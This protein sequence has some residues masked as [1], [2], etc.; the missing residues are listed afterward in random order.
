MAER[1]LITGAGGR[2]GGSLAEHKGSARGCIDLI[3][4]MHLDN[5]NVKIFPERGRH[6]ACQGD[7]EIDAK[8][9]V[10]GLDDHGL[11]G[12][13]LDGSLACRI[14][15]G[16]A[17]D[18]DGC[19]LCGALC[20]GRGGLRA[21]EVEDGAGGSDDGFA[22]VAD[23]NTKVPQSSKFANVLAERGTTGPFACA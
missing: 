19:M 5:L 23:R 20:K 2:I 15:A 3:A 7:E 14:Q 4:V 6:L 9:H 17:D 16:R 21:R 22:V 8:A 10:A 11:L 1:V 13:L 18:V 12:G